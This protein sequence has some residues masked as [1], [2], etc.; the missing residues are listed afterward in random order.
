M[1]HALFSQK[2]LNFLP[3]CVIKLYTPASDIFDLTICMRAVAPP[4]YSLV[5]ILMSSP[6]SKSS[7]SLYQENFGGGSPLHLMCQMAERFTLTDLE[8]A[9]P[10]SMEGLTE[11]QQKGIAST[12][13][14]LGSNSSEFLQ[15]YQ[16]LQGFTMLKKCMI[17]RFQVLPCIKNQNKNK[18]FCCYAFAH[19]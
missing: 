3:L 10:W 1:W 14:F 5:S 11:S 18:M 9:A 2:H 6:F 17:L 19:V 15:L 16:V 8:P 4:W 12:F 13:L 7:P